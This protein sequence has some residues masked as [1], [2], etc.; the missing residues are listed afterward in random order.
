[1]SSVLVWRGSVGDLVADI[2]VLLTSEQCR[3]LAWTLSDPGSSASSAFDGERDVVHKL[4]GGR[5]ACTFSLEV[6]GKWPEHHK[7][8]DSPGGE[9][10]TC[11]YCRDGRRWD[12]STRVPEGLS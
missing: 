8:D 5:A 4:V 6:P 2:R 7:W 9:N 3:E 11:V 10:V 1:M 12:W